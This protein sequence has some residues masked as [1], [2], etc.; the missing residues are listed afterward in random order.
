M[1][2][3]QIKSSAGQNAPKSIFTA[4]MNSVSQ[5]TCS[6]IYRMLILFWIKLEKIIIYNFFLKNKHWISLVPGM[7]VTG[8]VLLAIKF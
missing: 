1:G 3:I 8:T 2:I 6:L 4:E 5:F 7:K